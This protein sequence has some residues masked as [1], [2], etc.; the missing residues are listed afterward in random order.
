MTV[1]ANLIPGGQAFRLRATDPRELAFLRAER[2]SRQV[3]FLRKAL[4]VLAVLVLASYFISSS[5]SV[6]VGDVTA[7][8]SGV[9][10]SGGTLRMTNP[11][12]KGADKNNGEYVVSA[13]YADQDI[14]NPKVIKLHAIKAD[15]SSRSGGWSRMTAVRG[16]FDSRIEKLVMQ[17]RITV[18]TSSGVTGELKHATLDMK[19]QTLRSHQPVSFILPNGNVKANALTFESG[20]KTLTFRGKVKVHVVKK[21]KK[22]ADAAKPQSL[23]PQ[24]MVPASQAAPAPE[25]ALPIPETPEAPVGT[26]GVAPPAIPPLPQPAN[27]P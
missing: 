1:G 22:D 13:E 24:A 6:N 9:Q 14:K 7:T 20:K 11:K 5:L 15:V 2:H 27:A 10:V 4:P 21:Q 17:D 26:I 23:A 16:V 3:H 25:A 18:A 19:T 8:I 12:L